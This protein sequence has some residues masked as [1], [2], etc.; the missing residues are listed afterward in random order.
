MAEGCFARAALEAF[1]GGRLAE[2]ERAEVEAH[3]AQCLTCAEMLERLTRTQLDSLLG[4]GGSS[5]ALPT[6]ADLVL[7]TVMRRAAE[8]GAGT[9][10]PDPKR[11]LELLD[12]SAATDA[13]GTF[14]GYDVL[15]IAGRG[16]MGVVLRAR[17]GTLDRIV[18]LKVI[19]PTRGDDASF[20]ARFLDEARAV[21][22]IHHDHIVTVHQAGMAKGLAY[23]V[24]P[25]HAEGTL[26]GQ[27]A[28]TPK[29]APADVAR[30]GLQLALA[31]AAT[32]AQNILHRDLKPSNVLLEQ[33]LKRV[34]LA[35]FGLAQTHAMAEKISSSSS[36]GN[37]AQILRDNPIPT[38]DQSLL[39]SAATGDRMRAARTVA[40]TP[41][42]MSPE[43]ARGETIDTRSDLFGLGAVLFQMATGQT[44]Y[45]GESSKEVL[46]AATQ[47]EIK[48][49]REAAP[50]VPAALAGIIDRLLARRPED[51]FASAEEVVENLEALIHQ[52]HGRRFWLK[53]AAAAALAA[54]LI[55]SGTVFVLDWSGRTAIVNSLLCQRVRDSYYVRGRFGTYAG[56][57]DA[58]AAARPNEI[59][60]VRFSGE[61]QMDPFQVG[62]KPLTIRAAEGFRP[63]FVATNNAQPMILAD[64]PLALEGLTLWRRGSRA[65]FATLISVEDAPLHLLHCRLIRSRFQGQDVLVYGR[66]RRLPPGDPPLYRAL[67]GFQHGS[68][69]YLRNCLVVGSQAS[70]IQIRA[71]TNQPTRVQTENT[72]FAIDNVISIRP[73]TETSIALR[74]S[75]NVLLTGG[76]LDLDEAGPVQGISLALEDCLVDR[77]QGALI[78]VNQAH[79][80]DLLRALDWRETNV[81]YAGQGAFV[82]NRRRRALDTEEDWNERLKLGAGSHLLMNRQVFPETLVRS[83]LRLSAT[84]LNIDALA[85]NNGGRFNFAP[86]F[87]GEGEAYENFRRSVD[88]RAWRKQVRDAATNW[89]KRSAARPRHAA[90][91]EGERGL[92]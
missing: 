14:A 63:I 7:Q 73:E 35:D 30:V 84:D 58:L 38:E 2:R 32:H 60:E 79:D 80:G 61:R 15:G 17:D 21:A 78:R 28:K 71:S 18:A 85:R 56:L 57:S 44:L 26:E 4:S 11:V 19:F 3:L 6:P 52:E 10:C 83:S 82:L 86:Q 45:A 65:N 40:G 89:E 36:Q 59:V 13:L 29:F 47:G 43:Q 51:R 74:F 16:G 46:R 55:L 33:G 91:Q 66:L 42:Y 70:A 75:Q 5:A 90:R 25:F 77:T 87:V 31:L 69:G 1:V 8:S 34:R 64:A 24:M 92:P 20:T 27:L 50:E 37:E 39:E 12:P 48:P 23:L 76:L 41:H 53:R 49:V 68:A 67:L 88:Y 54:C 9:A 22:A 62:G 81:V 72:L